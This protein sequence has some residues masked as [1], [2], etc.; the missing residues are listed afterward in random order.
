MVDDVFLR[1]DA[2]VWIYPFIISVKINQYLLS[3]E[4]ISLATYLILSHLIGVIW[5]IFLSI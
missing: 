1:E 3:L 2:Y 4:R 5:V